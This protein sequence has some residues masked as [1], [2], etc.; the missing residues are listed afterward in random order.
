MN[1]Q[2]RDLIAALAEGRLSGPTADDALARIETDPEMSAEYA[3]QIAALEFLNSGAVPRMTASERETLHVNLTEQLGL[4]PKTMPVP[5]PA[6]RK[7]PWWQ[8]AFGVATAAA[9]VAAI[10]ILPGTL[11]GGSED[12]AALREVSADLDSSGGEE[13]QTTAAAAQVQ[14]AP[15]ADGQAFAEEQEIAV[16]EVY[17]TDSVKLG[18]L[19]DQAQGAVTPD[20][21]SSRLAPLQFTKRTILDTES[22]L[23]CLNELESDLPPGI[24]R[25]LPL[26]AEDVDGSTIAHLGFDFGSGVES[27]M[28]I[29]LSTCEIVD[30]DS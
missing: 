3:D 26:G 7:I 4:V 28:S 5:A 17:E 11:T 13:T 12:T 2:D 16:Y 23:E 19:L 10:V 27:A 20:D 8:P 14:E 1:D 15:A 18:D 24:E 29:D 9:I 25:F 22:V 21:V 6:K 30:S